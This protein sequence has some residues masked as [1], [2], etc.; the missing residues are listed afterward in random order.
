[1]NKNVLLVLGNGYNRENL[2]KS[3]LYLRDNLGVE[4][5]PI[6]VRDVRKKE[7]LPNAID[8]IMLEPMIAG[9]NK[10]W[11]EYED[12]EILK[13]QDLLK[14]NG[15]EKDLEIKYGITP[16]IVI[17]ELKKSDMLL[18]EKEE[19]FTEDL[20][21]LMKRFFKPII[22]VRDKPLKLDKISIA[23]DDGTK[24]NKS[25]QRFSNIFDIKEVRS[26][27]LKE[28]SSDEEENYLET[29]ILNKG[30]KL[31]S[32]QFEKENIEEFIKECN[33]ADILVMGNLS[34]SYLF[35]KITKKIGIKIMESVET[36]LFIA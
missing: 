3:A 17:Q 24:V 29:F 6:H 23:N 18:I 26:L 28:T 20:I 21:V 34:N 15:I 12:K 36:T 32:K 10:E 8:G 2:I 16:E 22:V 25:F 11:T 7:F 35:E 14:K 33:K 4:I 13:I 1:M 27:K 31:T 9:V 19:K 5:R 30:L